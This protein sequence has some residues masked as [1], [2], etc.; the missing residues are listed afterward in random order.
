M[1]YCRISGPTRPAEPESAFL[2]RFP[3]VFFRLHNGR[4]DVVDQFPHG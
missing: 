4:N 2:T 1:Q 3:G